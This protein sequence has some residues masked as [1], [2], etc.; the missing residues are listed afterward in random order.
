M[1]ILIILNPFRV[2]TSLLEVSSASKPLPMAKA[3]N[4]AF[5]AVI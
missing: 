5:I 4:V 2:R 1:N 3:A